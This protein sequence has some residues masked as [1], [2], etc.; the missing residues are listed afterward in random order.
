MSAV[1]LIE[2][3]NSGFGA[4]LTGKNSCVAPEAKI[5]LTR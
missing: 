2:R 3:H 4:K 5:R 1:E